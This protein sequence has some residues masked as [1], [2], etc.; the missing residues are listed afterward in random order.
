MTGC[1]VISRK[2]F[3]E[4]F[5]DEGRAAGDEVIEDRAEAVDVG[6]GG[7]VADFSGGLLR[8]HVR[9][10]AEQRAGE[11]AGR[12]RLGVEALGDA[13]VGDVRD[14]V[15][16]EEDVRGFEVAMED[17][18]TVAVMDGAA[19]VAMSR[20]AAMGARYSSRCAERSPPSTNFIV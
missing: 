3:A 9:G 5:G 11:R 18:A 12:D 2:L 14:A 20:A 13:E 17:A 10:R 16:V 4:R 1:S 6:G 7:D 8:G 15:D 19:Q